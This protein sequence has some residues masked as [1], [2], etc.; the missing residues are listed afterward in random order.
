[1][2]TMLTFVIL[3]CHATTLFLGLHFLEFG[4][5]R[6]WQQI[7]R[8]IWACWPISR[9]WWKRKKWQD[10]ECFCLTTTQTEYRWAGTTCSLTTTSALLCRFLDWLSRVFRNA[11]TDCAPFNS[12]DIRRR[13]HPSLNYE[14]LYTLLTLLFFRRTQLFYWCN[15]LV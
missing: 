2:K 15:L 1:M 7:C 3:Y 4:D 11:V 12:H 10:P 8:S 9:R 5:H 13:W 14:S 6:Y